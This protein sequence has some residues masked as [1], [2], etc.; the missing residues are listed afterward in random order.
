MERMRI[1]EYCLKESSDALFMLKT[2]VRG[3]FR[4]LAQESMRFEVRGGE[5]ERKEREKV[6]VC[7]REIP[8]SGE[9]TFRGASNNEWHN[10]WR[11]FITSVVYLYYL[12]A[13]MR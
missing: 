12:Y 1:A 3:A 5:D 13:Y 8:C 9:H 11:Y 10:E 7:V 4:E 6:C 2:K